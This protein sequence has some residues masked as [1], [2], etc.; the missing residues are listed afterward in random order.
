MA[1]R[2]VARRAVSGSA[3][4]LVGVIAVGWASP[5]CYPDQGGQTAPPPSRFDYP[6]GI[7]VSSGGNVLYV[8]N[9]DDDEQWN[10]ATLQS[11]DLFMIRRHTAELI[12]ADETGVP[13]TDPIPFAAGYANLENDEGTW[14]SCF[15]IG[16]APPVD[17]T[18]PVYFKDSA[19]IGALATDLQLSPSG[20]RLFAPVTS[21]ASVTWAEVTPDD[22]SM[23]PPGDPPPANEPSPP[24]SCPD[25]VAT[26]PC[27]PPFHLDCGQGQAVAGS[28]CDTMHQAGNDPNEPGD[29]RNETM[30]GLPFGI[31]QS[32]DGTAMA[33]THLAT[34]ETSLLLTG[35]AGVQPAALCP[36]GTAVCNPS[37]QFVLEGLPN[38]G[39]GITQVPHDPDAVVRCE[40][41]A[42]QPP[43]V[44]QAFL[45]TSDVA[46]EVDL[47]RYYDDDGSS[48]HRPFLEDERAYGIGI[49]PGNDQR[50]IVVDPTPSLVC[51]AR[52][53]RLS[54]SEACGQ[55]PGQPLSS[56]CIAC[57]QT[58]SR[59]FIASRAPASVFYGQVGQ[60]SMDGDGTFDP[61]ALLLQGYVPVLP[62]PSMVYLA[63]KVDATGHFALRLFVVCSDASAI[64]VFD[65]DQIA[66]LGSHAVPE[67][68]I[69]V[70][71]GPFAMA[72]DPFTFEDV[73]A[74]EVDAA[75]PA[76]GT[77]LLVA[78]DPRQDK[79]LQLKTYRFGYVA[80]YTNSYVQV[81]DLDSSLTISGTP[82][83]RTFEQVVFTLGQLATP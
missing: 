1:W 30:P 14:N 41:V 72:F 40:D 59:V 78:P 76:T 32:E 17:S 50:G 36:P 5:A 19:V 44:Q 29:T 18:N 13:P 75:L 4:V 28:P 81:I 70:G 27:W 38:G 42:D 55:S 12:M 53:A 79:A 21:N 52:L 68:V 58:P 15:G 80:S 10:G 25:D 61:D 73:A 67:A 6:A 45:E 47:L 24:A 60:V 23:P 7:A 43:C 39:N 54:P 8:V 63:P 26:G 9:S 31:A 48:L 37:M 34:G 11:Y 33:V 82:N 20:T 71:A 64:F 22:P 77:P 57:G 3:R 56:A 46:A 83:Q 51:K 62:G 69:N 35:L 2:S 49:V 74:Q 65:P 66:V 16:C